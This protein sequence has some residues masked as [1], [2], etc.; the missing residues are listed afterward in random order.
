MKCKHYR[1][2]MEDWLDGEL[3]GAARA[4]LERHVGA[5]SACA[6]YFAQ[7]QAM[8]AA[9]KKT[10]QEGSAGLHFQPRPLTYSPPEERLAGSMSGRPRVGPAWRRPWLGLAPRAFAALAA[11]MLFALLFLFHP[12]TSPRP[13]AAAGRSPIAEIT[14]SDSLNIVDEAII[15]GCT[16]GVCYSIDMQISTVEINLHE[17]DEPL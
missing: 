15:T 8:G 10:L 1:N 13:G 9:L 14:I 11:V 7:R 16:S 5:C 2:E 17:Q 12:G 4:E 6:R 3:A